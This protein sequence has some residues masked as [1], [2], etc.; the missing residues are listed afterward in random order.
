MCLLSTGCAGLN[1]ENIPDAAT[2]DKVTGFRYYDT[3]PFLLLHTDNKGG[4]TTKLLYLPDTQKKRSIKPYAYAATNNATLSFEEGRL[5][6]AKAEIDETAIPTAV[7]SALEKVATEA[8]KAMNAGAGGIPSPYLFRI[9][10]VDNTWVLSGGQAM[11]NDK[12]ILIRYR[13]N[14]GGQ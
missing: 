5:K 13:A 9:L 14:G 6:G 10:K 7:L 4:L 12:A 2:D 8:I 1:V 3:S 11:D